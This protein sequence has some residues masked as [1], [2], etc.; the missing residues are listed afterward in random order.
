MIL[1]PRMDFVSA[2]FINIYLPERH[3]SHMH[4]DKPEGTLFL[5][6]L[7]S[8]QKNEHAHPFYALDR[9]IQANIG[10]LTD[11][12]IPTFTNK[13]EARHCCFSSI[14]KSKGDR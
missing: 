11:S 14:F 4:K 3:G 6:H 10:L 2:I 12:F 8:K 5:D 1:N 7:T 9:I 13:I